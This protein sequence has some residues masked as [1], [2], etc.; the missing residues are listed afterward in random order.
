M[1][2]SLS[3]S[4]THTLSLTQTSPDI[5]TVL[6]EVKRKQQEL[7]AADIKQRQPRERQQRY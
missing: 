7:R 6:T 2:L 3:L 5:E 4:H 1:V